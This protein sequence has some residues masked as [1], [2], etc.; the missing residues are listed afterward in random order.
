MTGTPSS[1]GGT[2]SG[3]LE[4]AG[5]V[6]AIGALSLLYAV[7]HAQGAHPIAFILYAVLASALATL[8]TLGLGSQ[9]LAIV[10]HPMSWLVGLAM[11]LLEI[12]YYQ[13]LT[14]V[15]PAHGNVMLR[16][17]I[18][19]SMI[20]GWVLLRRRAPPLAIA[21]ALVVVGAIVFLVVVT[22]P[23][24]RWPMAVVGTLA[25]ACMVV[26]GFAAE[27][28]PWN[29][30]ASTV[31]DKL[32]VTGLVLLVTS[33][34]SLALTALAA[35]AMAAGALP[36]TPLVPTAA[37]MLHAPTLLLG[38]LAGGAVYTLMMYLN[39]ASVV[40]ITTENL[41]AMMAFS[42][43]TAWVFQELG[44]LLGWIHAPTPKPPIV[45]AIVVCILAVLLI[46]WS[47]VGA[48]RRRA[49]AP[50]IA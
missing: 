37:Q 8:A 42:P 40:K 24:V 34:L 46:F 1:P 27:F 12:L 2:A 41:T 49:L 44:A 35:A 14:Y 21:G 47:G 50:S 28:H 9:A 5:C 7:G 48:R 43:A 33:V 36:R 30:S 13:T 16:I 11:I 38:G 17:G 32:R 15:T 25:A 26:R 45:A 4:A 29:R 20:A 23:E 18:P 22:A 10:R 39:F 3:W 19:I 31:Q 6:T